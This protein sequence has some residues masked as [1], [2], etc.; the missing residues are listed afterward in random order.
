VK[1]LFDLLPLLAFFA[2]YYLPKDMGGGIYA[3]TAGAIVVGVTQSAYLWLRH[4][5]V[6]KL[7]LASTGLLAL[8]G[9]I[10]LA[11]KDPT[12]IKWK[13]TAV[14][15][16]FA[17]VF[18]AADLSGRNLLR[19][20]MGREIELAGTDWRVLSMSWVGFFA[21]MG[22]LNLY[23]AYRYAEEVWVNFK[24]FGGL[25]CMIVFVIAQAAWLTRRARPAGAGD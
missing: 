16:L 21:V 22:V 14:Y 1:I 10:T 3:A 5:R 13:P 25:G 4:R 15:W 12:F 11:L 18:L 23:I 7:Q 8:L 17:L 9:G 20:T 2:G 6:D 24:V 19:A